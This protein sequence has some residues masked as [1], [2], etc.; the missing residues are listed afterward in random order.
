MLNGYVVRKTL[1][2]PALVVWVK[3]KIESQPKIISKTVNF[4]CSKLICSEVNLKLH[5]WETD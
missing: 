2:T 3:K 1:G 5:L 4:V